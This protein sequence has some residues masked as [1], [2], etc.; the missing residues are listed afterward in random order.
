MDGIIQI[1]ASRLPKNSK[2]VPLWWLVSKVIVSYKAWDTLVHTTTLSMAKVVGHMDVINYDTK[3]YFWEMDNKMPFLATILLLGDTNCDTL[4]AFYLAMEVGEPSTHCIWLV[5][6]YWRW[7][8]LTTV[9]ICTELL[10]WKLLFLAG[11]WEHWG[12]YMTSNRISGKEQQSQFYIFMHLDHFWSEY[13]ET[14]YQ[15]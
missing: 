13:L 3:V 14:S 1:H 6:V 2:Y 15:S 7:K 11:M 8:W 10:F 4:S 9:C 5:H 12:K